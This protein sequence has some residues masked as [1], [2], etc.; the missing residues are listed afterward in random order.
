MSTPTNPPTTLLATLAKLG[1]G[2]IIAGSIVGSG[3]LIATTKVGAEAGFWLLWL[4]I[5]GCVIKVFTQVEMGRYTI[6]WSETPLEALN[7]VPGPRWKVNWVVWYWAVMTL[8]IISQQGGIVG[9]VGQALAISQPLTE[10]GETYNDI[11]NERVRAQVELAMGTGDR[12][13][14]QERFDAATLAAGDLATP[15]DAYLWA[16]IIAVATSVLMYFGRFG[17]IQAVSTV[18]VALFTLITVVTLIL[19][20]FT[21]WAVTGSEFARGL[22]FSLPPAGEADGINPMVTAL[23][24]FGIIGMGAGELLMYP[25][26]CL[27]KGYARSTGRRDDSPQWLD[28]AKGWIHVLQLDAW[29]SAVVYTFAT[30]AFY[31]LGA[32][33]LWR[34]GLN[35]AGGD[36][37]RTL[38]EM[39]VPVFGSWSHGVFLF[40]AFAVLY[41]TFFVVAA[42]YS[43]LVADGL[44]L[45]G[46]HDG[47]EATRMRWTRWISCVW[48]FLALGTY[49]FFQAPVAMVLASGVAQAVMLPMLGIAALFFRYR[50]ADERLL[51]GKLWDV[52]LWISCL[53]FLVAG[54]WSLYN[55]L[56]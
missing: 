3:E 19:L 23:A 45:F 4:I 7:K 16:T 9:G 24:A 5:A 20:Q 46:L 56:A 49:L 11:Q 36:M 43:R 30:V 39:Y 31:L 1:P 10:Q 17:L 25:Y 14:A 26:W 38:A 41:S 27:E 13:A 47:S 37:V 6:T 35:P 33:V 32:A 44:G 48:P 42:G 54:A 8:L 50:R 29:L 21:D 51:P 22:T 52:M 18:L 2:M 15:R 12:A 40:G 34:T 28:R 53:G 55:T